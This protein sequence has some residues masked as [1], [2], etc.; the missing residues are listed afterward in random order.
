M[1]PIVRLASLALVLALPTVVGARLRLWSSFPHQEP[2]TIDSL[3]RRG[4]LRLAVETPTLSYFVDR[5]VARGFEYDLLHRFASRNQARLEPQVVL[6]SREAIA[7]LRN[8]LADVAVVP[9]ALDP[10]PLGALPVRPY[11]RGDGDPAFP[12]TGAVYVREDSPALLLALDRY[13]ARADGNG[14]ANRLFHRYFVDVPRGAGPLLA[15][16]IVRL[17]YWDGLIAKHAEKA[18]FDWRLIAALISIESRFDPAAVSHKGATGLMQL[19]PAAARDVKASRLYVPAENI[20]AGVA[21][22]QQLSRMFAASSG[23]D[24]LRTVLAAYLLGA[25]PVID[26]QKIALELALDPTR[27]SDLREALLLL[28]DEEWASRVRHG[29]AA[30]RHA[31]AYVDRVFRRYAEYRQRAGERPSETAALAARDPSA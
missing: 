10:P 4:V 24:H 2:V 29:R 21:Y 5:G 23:E 25:G 17:S 14:T 1:K 20:R 31:V 16:R 19:M 30:G 15:D 3:A 12:A 28:E 7:L 27:W 9:E 26:A 11:L 8:G 6:S 13:L 22:L 18:G